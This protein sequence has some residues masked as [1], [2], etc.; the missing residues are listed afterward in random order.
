MAI[1]KLSNSFPGVGSSSAAASL[2]NK[3]SRS[4]T[5]ETRNSTLIFPDRVMS[6]FNGWITECSIQAVSGALQNYGKVSFPVEECTVNFSQDIVQHKRPNVPGARVEST[7]F[8]PIIFKVKAPFLF[9]LQRGKGET[10]SNL[11]PETFSKVFSILT[12]KVSPVLIFTH[13]TMGQFTVKPQSGSTTVSSNIRNGQILEFE[14]VQANEDKINVSDI[15]DIVPF[16]QAQV[17]ATLFDSAIVLLNPAPP[18]SIT[19]ISLTKLLQDIRGAIDS[20]SLFINQVTNLVNHAINQIKMIEDALLRLKTAA[21]AG[22][23]TQLKRIKAGVL[24]LVGNQVINLRIPPAGTPG[25][26]T[27]RVEPGAGGRVPAHPLIVPPPGIAPPRS[28]NTAVTAAQLQ[29]IQSINSSK[30]NA[31]N[32]T[33]GNL[34]VYVVA[35][36]MTLAN[37]ALLTHNTIEQLIRLN[38]AI[39]K[40]PS[41]KIG[42]QIV[43]EASTGPSPQQ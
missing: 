16:G 36:E 11:Y 43:F 34:K 20:A 4:G 30:T 39:A 18:S 41:L 23:L 9:G 19:S 1:T 28:P 12:D 14:L 33:A 15:T 8:N 31:G 10:W 17:A 3:V 27:V 35:H 29:A 26:S 22:L 6:T 32:S 24:S 5:A 21:T 7:G 38:P 37:V 42:T 40:T 13:P 2:T 25:H